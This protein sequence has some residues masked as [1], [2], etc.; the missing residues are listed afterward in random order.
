[1]PMTSAMATE[2]VNTP[3]V[4]KIGRMTMTPRPEV[5]CSSRPHRSARRIQIAP[6]TSEATLTAAMQSLWHRG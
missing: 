3:G 4:V 1:M 2:P 5:S 6:G